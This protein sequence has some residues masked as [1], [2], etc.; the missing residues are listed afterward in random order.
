[1]VERQ[2]I[3]DDFQKPRAHARERSEEAKRGH[4]EKCASFSEEQFNTLVRRSA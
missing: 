1:L 3:G 2:R 4:Q